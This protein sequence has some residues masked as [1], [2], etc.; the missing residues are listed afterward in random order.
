MAKK[1]RPYWQVDAKWLS[2]VALM[3]CLALTL[4]V[5]ALYGATS[6]TTGRTVIA[7]LLAGL[8]SKEGLD[9]EADVA[10]LRTRVHANGSEMFSVC[11]VSVTLTVHDVDT[12]TARELRLKVFGAFADR[13]YE[14]GPGAAASQCRDD[15]GVTKAERDARFVRP[16]T[17]KGH[18]AIGRVLLVLGGV[19]AVLLGLVVLFSRRFGRLVSPGLVL[20]L[21]GLPGLLFGAFAASS[22][23]PQAMARAG[24]EAGSLAALGSA[25]GFVV[26]LVIHDFVWPYLATLLTGVVLLVIAL[27]GTVIWRVRRTRPAPAADPGGTAETASPTPGAAQPAA[28]TTSAEPD[29]PVSVA[30]GPPPA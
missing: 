15:A 17:R 10:S 14:V 28:V 4:P 8:T 19:D 7:H 16:F 12:L 30:P 18:E 3:F 5:A 1:I 27:I 9:S 24:E 26:P 22:S 23:E 21:V 25:A 29:P 6:P 11:G 13:L 20:T 2:A